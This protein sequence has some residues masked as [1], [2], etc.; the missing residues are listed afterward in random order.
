MNE[1]ITGLFQESIS[2]I[3]LGCIYAL[4]A[5]GFTLIYKA[6]E[7]VNFAQG[8]VMMVGA[9]VNFFFVS[10]FSSMVGEV[11][12]WV[13]LLAFLG[14]IIFAV[15]FGIILD[16]I[17]NRPL[18]D[19]PVFSIVM[20]TISLAIILR[21]LTALIAGPISLVPQSPF[22]GSVMEVGGG[23]VSYLELSIIF[24]AVVLMG[25][26]FVFFNK[27]R[28]GIAM[29][30]T[31][32]DS[33]AAQ[34][35]GIPVKKVYM[36]VWVFA[37]IVGVV[38]GILLAPRM[39]LLDTSMGFLGLKAFPAAIL[40][41]F[42]SIPGAVVGGIILGVIETVSMGTL[43]FHFSWIKE[44]N[45]IIVWIVLIVVLMVRPD[46]LFGKAKVKRV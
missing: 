29:K 20:A 24:S 4:I 32:E 22:D 8:E 44:I 39:S 14:S 37:A 42:G 27:T 45:D 36:I 18:K 35:M 43:S 31:S 13:F 5:L 34:L 6:S 28:W 16:L 38:S 2:G 10:Y 3:A 41:G 46:G 11:N 25:L 40:G 1:L 17:I 12:G 23:V 19:E 33:E 7:V 9:Y 30:A 15:I 26:F 21:A